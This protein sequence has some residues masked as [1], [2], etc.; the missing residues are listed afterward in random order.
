M[1]GKAIGQGAAAVSLTVFRALLRIYPRPFRERYEAEMV[2]VFCDMLRSPDRHLGAI[3]RTVLPDMVVS[4][5]KARSEEMGRGMLALLGAAI[6]VGTAI[7][8]VDSRPNWDDTG[9]TAGA[10]LLTSALFG[11]AEPRRPWVWALAVGMG[12]PLHGILRNGNFSMLLVLAFTFA[13][14][15]IGAALR[16]A[17]APP[18]APMGNSR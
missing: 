13:G 12:I 15:Y 10:L 3:W 7:T 18:A 11:A 17:F 6:A 1:G 16:R 8:W 9:I 4:G 14:A 2:Q 5:M